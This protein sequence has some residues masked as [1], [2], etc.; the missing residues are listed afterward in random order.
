MSQPMLGSPDPDLRVPV[1]VFHEVDAEIDD[2]I[3]ETLQHS[4]ALDFT[5]VNEYGPARELPKQ[6]EPPVKNAQ[7]RKRKP[8]VDTDSEISAPAKPAKSAK[9]KKSR[10]NKVTAF[11]TDEEDDAP[12]LS[13]RAYLHLET[14]ATQPS[15]ARGKPATPV[16]KTTQCAPFI[17]FT[18]SKFD[19][20][21]AAVA[22]AAKTTVV[23]LPMSRLWW[24]FET[25]ASLPM[26]VL[27]NAVG[28]AAMIDAVNERTKG[29]TVFLYL[30]KPIDLEPPAEVVT[31]RNNPA[32]EYDEDLAMRAGFSAECEELE[33]KFPIGNHILFPDKRIYTKSG[34]FWELTSLRL[35]IWAAAIPTKCATFDAPPTSNMFT[36]QQTIKPPCPKQDAPAELFIAY[37]CYL[38]GRDYVANATVTT[39]PVPG[40]ALQQNAALVPLHGY[41]PP[42][43]YYMHA[44]PPGHGA[45]VPYYP[46]YQYQYYPPPAFAPPAQNHLLPPALPPTLPHPGNNTMPSEFLSPGITTKH[47]VALETF[48][49]KSMISSSD[50]DKLA[51]LGYVPGNHIVELLGDRDWQAVG[52]TV[53]AWHTFLSHHHKFCTAIIAGTWA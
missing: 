40:P 53:V 45:H 43:P 10:K 26:K 25:P 36:K 6:Q 17:F 46:R 29:H 24:K 11:D 35:D 42:L 34:Q 31:S 48:C 30:P 23:N 32:Y 8:S 12:K 44:G 18:D 52:F 2:L 7:G 15:R 21:V 5:F 51:L 20:F 41:P 22:E 47:K 49:Q 9:T 39:P 3:S 1:S 38:H 27:S 4:P 50:A 14:V 16:T 33:R 28:Y 13:I 19:F 37:D